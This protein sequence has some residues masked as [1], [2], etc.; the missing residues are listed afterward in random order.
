[1]L[2]DQTAE[3]NSALGIVPP[4]VPNA[5]WNIKA[6]EIIGPWRLRVVFNDGL[7][8]EVD[9]KAFIHAPRAGVFKALRDLDAF[10]Q[11]YLQWG[12]LTWPG[13]LDLA[14]DTMHDA[15]KEAG[16]YAPNPL[17][18]LRE[19]LASVQ[20]RIASRRRRKLPKAG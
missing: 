13:E 19:K 5:P 20:R 1:M 4:I 9:L 15:I 14:P 10:E 11:V 2:R 6:A 17:E 8:G 12:A 3:A 16:I 18:E 7:E